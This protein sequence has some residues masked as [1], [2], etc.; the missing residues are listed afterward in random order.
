M[1]VRLSAD[2]QENTDRDPPSSASG[3]LRRAGKPCP[4]IRKRNNKMSEVIELA[5]R[6]VE[7]K[8]KLAKEASYRLANLSTDIKNKALDEMA[9]AIDSAAKDIID[10][11]SLDI[12]SAYKKNTSK[13]L[14]DR[15]TIDGKR[16]GGMVESLKVVRALPDPVGRTI[17]KWTRP[18]GL[19]I[20][21]RRVP[22]GVIGIVYE[23]RPNVTVDSAALCLKSGNAVV[24]RGGSDA[25]NSNIILAKL[26]S[27]AA[28][29]SGVPNGAINLIESTDRESVTEMLKLNKFIDV[30]IPRG[31]AGLI[32]HTIENSTIPVIETGEGNC[33]A[34]V[35]ASADLK[36]AVEIVYN[37]KVQRPSV[38]N[39]IETL[40]VDEAIAAEFLPVV[41]KR[42]KEAHVELRGD[43]KARGIDPSIKAAT[44]EDWKTEYLAL[45]LAVKVVS[46]V[47]EA[48]KHIKT[49][50]TRHSEAIMTRDKAK[51]KMFTD[52][53][54]AAAVYVN[55]STRF[56]DG[57][58]FG[59]GAEI[60]ISTQKLHAR[61]PMG[62]N[63][64]TSYK[65][66]VIGSGQ[67]R[68]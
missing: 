26:I 59:F 45:I 39:A 21:K 10:A 48:I 19:K 28:T 18:N 30:I 61:G 23:A 3:G 44:E 12:E 68:K 24:L 22:L 16:I 6:E 65:Y 40:L 64:L 27:E 35:E 58:E 47:D 4:Y 36:K 34:Y 54:D 55:A 15:L 56:T 67:V 13:A 38:C 37:A 49:Y 8:A 5:L 20:I 14:V 32:K 41:F 25:I 7:G 17:A 63:E 51:A 1:A 31:G 53:V 46:G 62:L 43:E 11:N 57:G 29:K 52:E 66:V 33:H 9:K 60:G 2:R 50:G 42:L